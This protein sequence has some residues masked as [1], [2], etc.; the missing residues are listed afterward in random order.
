LYYLS[1]IL[2]SFCYFK[3]FFYAF[4]ANDFLGLFSTLN[5]SFHPV[6]FPRIPPKCP[7]GFRI[8]CYSPFFLPMSSKKVH[9]W[10]IQNQPLLSPAIHAVFYF[11]RGPRQAGNLIQKSF[12]KYRLEPSPLPS[13]LSVKFS[14]RVNG[15]SDIDLP[16]IFGILS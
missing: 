10:Y 12:I 15:T 16:S 4:S 14:P 13:F 7:L 1:S 8:R 3:W 5:F 6:R 9:L 11:C 2:F